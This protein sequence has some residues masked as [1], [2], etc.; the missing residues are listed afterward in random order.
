MEIK[1][2]YLQKQ[3]KKKRK[4]KEIEFNYNIIMSENYFLLFF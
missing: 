4:C 3:I 2:I 1:G